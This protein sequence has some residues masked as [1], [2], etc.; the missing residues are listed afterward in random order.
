MLVLASTSQ[1]R[2]GLLERL[3]VPFEIAA[4]DVDESE[5]A[6]ESPRETALRLAE[7][8]ARAVAGAHSGDLI[9][10]SDQ[11][12]DLDGR[13]LGKPGGHS[14]A[15]EQLQAM[16]GRVV[17]FHTAL[18]LLDARSGRCEL[19]DVPTAVRFRRFSDAQA[20]RYLEADTPYDC[21]G[22]AKIE[23]LGIALV[24]SVESSDPSALIGLPLIALVSMLQRTGNEVP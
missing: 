24:E 16:R 17:V 20:A 4:P 12:A 10:G 2:R 15:L 13:P 21:A 11:V 23:S 7:T 6:G 1:Y 22:S 18:C 3:R 14:A 8:K 5:R 19:E 9:I